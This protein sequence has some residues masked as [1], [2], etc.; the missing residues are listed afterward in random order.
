MQSRTGWILC[1]LI[2]ALPA[3]VLTVPDSAAQVKGKP[4]SGMEALRYLNSTGQQAKVE[5]YAL[6]ILWDDIRQP[7]CL[8][9]LCRALEIVRKNEDA[10]V[11]NTILLRVLDEKA[12]PNDVTKY[13]AAA[14][15]RLAPLNKGF[16]AQRAKYAA[17]AAGK[18]FDSPESVDD[19]W[20]TQVKCDLN[21]PHN[22]YAWKL[23][24]GRK[25]TK[26]DWIH[27]AQGVMHRS[28]MKFVDSLDGRKGALFAVPMKA[29]SEG[30]K[31]LGHPT[32]ITMTNTGKGNFLRIGAKG[33]N[34]PFVLKV[35]A[36]GKEIFS[37]TISE[38]A[39]SDLKIDLKDAAG[40]AEEVT[41]ELVVPEDQRY[42]EGAWIDYMDFF[43]N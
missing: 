17:S 5:D 4:L 34:F 29:S 15:K 26:P 35:Y 31:K 10:A 25:D 22:L 23:V 3:C 14:E 37:E 7:E 41:V 40:K 38:K 13:K 39:W 20:M 9:I 2:V 30:A 16:E 6:R 42:M 28:G 21:A 24:G 12:A 43:E 11:W 27:N 36:S 32:Q 1:L 18:K 19:L 8:D 33:Y